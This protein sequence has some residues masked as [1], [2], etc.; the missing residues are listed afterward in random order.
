MDAPSSRPLFVDLDGTIIASDMMVETILPLLKRQPALVWK[1]PFWLLKGRAHLKHQLAL[2]STLDAGKL[3]Y[4]A[5]V[6][7]FVAAERRAGREVVLA[8]A[9][10]A[11][12]AHAVA[13]ELKCFNAV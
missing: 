2:H 4:R 13:D 12:W 1:L 3:P 8:T 5:D 7:D 6:V 11:R 10:D 9:S